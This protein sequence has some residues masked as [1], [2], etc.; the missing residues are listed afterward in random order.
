MLETLN[1]TAPRRIHAMLLMS[2]WAR[3]SM[4]CLPS[5][6]KEPRVKARMRENRNIPIT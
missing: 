1:T 6:P 4:K 2:A 5:E 3:S